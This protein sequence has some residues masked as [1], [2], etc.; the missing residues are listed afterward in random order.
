LSREKVTVFIV[1][2]VIAS[3]NVAVMVVPTAT[4]VALLAGFVAKTAGSA[5][6]A[7]ALSWSE[8]SA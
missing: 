8:A 3:L 6:S 1:D 5:A 4:P 7:V 2:A